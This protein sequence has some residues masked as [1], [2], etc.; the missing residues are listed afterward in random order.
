MVL[1]LGT[2]LLTQHINGGYNMRNP[3]IKRFYFLFIPIIAFIIGYFIMALIQSNGWEGIIFRDTQPKK[4]SFPAD[5]PP[6]V[7]TSAQSSLSSPEEVNP[8]EG[9][10][11]LIFEGPKI[12]IFFVQ[13]AT[14]TSEEG[15]RKKLLDMKALGF[16]GSLIV[17]GVIHVV[18]AGA[19][20]LELA[21]RLIEHYRGLNP[22]LPF[23]IHTMT[24]SPLPVEGLSQS[25][26]EGLTL[27]YQQVSTLLEDA[28]RY[29]AEDTLEKHTA[30]ATR[31]FVEKQQLQMNQIEDLQNNLTAI[32][33]L[34]LPKHNMGYLLDGHQLLIAGLQG[35]KG[36]DYQK[37]WKL[38]LDQLSLYALLTQQ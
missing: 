29:T 24:L 31:D 37:N 33:G 18:L 2:P 32:Q 38:L 14:F 22:D 19:P 17:D 34:E 30:K 10:G 13:V 1:L 35:N 4:L 6:K 9:G 25:Q 12:R 3:Q 36:L 16:E 8:I 7:T 21:D 28:C 26:Y 11:S 27:L 15:A 20:D 5:K 23:V